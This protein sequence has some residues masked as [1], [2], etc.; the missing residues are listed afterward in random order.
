M[1]RIVYPAIAGSNPVGPA[2]SLERRN[3]L[4]DHTNEETKHRI[5]TNVVYHSPDSDQIARYSDLRNQAGELAHL[6]NHHCPDS[7][8]KSLALT[9]LEQTVMWANSAIARN[10]S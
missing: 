2:N 8:E 6:I 5:G 7:R 9:N 3:V 1:H 4:T 10:E